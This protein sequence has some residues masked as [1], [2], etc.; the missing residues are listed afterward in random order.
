[1]KSWK[2]TSLD[3]FCLSMTIKGAWLFRELPSFESMQASLSK[4]L[5]YY[6]QLLG[7]YD[8]K[9]KSVILQ[10][11]DTQNI[12]FHKLDC[13]GKTSAQDLYSLVPKYDLKAFKE[14]K[15]QAF[16]AYYLTL[17]D[18]V[19]L[20]VQCAHATMDGY[21]FYNL[22][23][24]WAA[25]NRGEEIV[26]MVVDQSLIPAPDSLTKEQTISK[27]QEKGWPRIKFRQLFK[28]MFNLAAMNI[29]KDTYTIELSQ[30]DIA[31]LKHKD[32]V[33]TN[34]ALS[35]LACRRLME[36]LPDK[37]EFLLL[38]VA[39]LRGRACGVP[40]N[41]FGNFS[42]AT[43]MGKLGREAWARD[44]EKYVSA[45]LAQDAQTETTQLSV[46]SSNY[47][48]PYY[49]FDASDMNSRN[50][51]I[52]YINNQLKFRPGELD[53]GTGMALKA[54]QAELPDM[55][56]FWQPVAGGPVQILYRGF[57]AKIMNRK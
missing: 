22:V 21:T 49:A 32:S 3:T 57:A 48:L 2:L 33:G 20:V 6:P 44:I 35:S 14:G 25:L 53:F 4:L 24:Q 12:E 15:I 42:N 56:K 40:E 45:A 52:V 50:P 11:S 30:E 31:G 1:M 28:M 10:D 47:S 39:D 19:A 7:H 8:E 43:V 17:E 29:I 5:A 36:N 34:A 46:C 23:K 26:P 13:A 16:S 27:I 38:Q 37:K 9:Y 54:F 51:G 41:F 55:V 18:G